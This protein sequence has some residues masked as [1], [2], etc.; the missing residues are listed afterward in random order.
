MVVALSEAAAGDETAIRESFHGTSS[1]S[2]NS[3]KEGIS[4]LVV[5]AT[6]EP[7]THAANRNRAAAVA[8][9]DIIR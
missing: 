6:H 3:S 8:T 4:N 5:L 1:S 9:G 7:R 2:P